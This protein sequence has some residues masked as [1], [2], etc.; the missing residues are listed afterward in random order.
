MVSFIDIHRDEYGVE[1]ICKV[2]EIAPSTYF[3]HARERRRPD[4]R[5]TRARA[6]EKLSVEIRRVYDE[7]AGV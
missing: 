2:L 4:L 7:S 6:D 3:R 1:P 5:S